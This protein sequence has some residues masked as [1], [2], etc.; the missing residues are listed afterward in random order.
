MLNLTKAE[1]SEK[2][3][4]LN[5]TRDTLEKALRLAEILTYLNTNPIMKDVLP[6]KGGTAINFTIFKLPR[7]S[8]DIDLDFHS[9]QTREEMLQSRTQITIDIETHMKTQEYTREISRKPSHSLEPLV[10]SYRNLGGSKDN[11]KIEINYSLR[12]HIFPLCIRS[13]NS[14]LFDTSIRVLCLDPIEIFASKINALINRAAAR[15]LYDIHN[16]ISFDI[17]SERDYELLRKATI[18][19]TAISQE[20]IPNKYDFSKIEQISSR[21]IKTELQPVIYKNESISLESMK[22]KVVAFLSQLLTLSAEEDTFLTEF[23]NNNFLPEL[24]FEDEELLA[25]IRNHPMALWKTRAP[26]SK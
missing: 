1:L 18:F 26:G 23:S 22:A 2:A 16:M 21:K 5:F 4:E 9:T 3:I 6:L 8:V 15:D 17:L 20:S 25:R 14:E 19:Y 24:L 10:F 13:I 12:S 11:I 7:L